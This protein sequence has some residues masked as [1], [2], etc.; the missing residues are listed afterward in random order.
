M[1]KKTLWCALTLVLLSAAAMSGA[2]KRPM[3]DAQF[4]ISASQ[5]FM[6]M[7]SAS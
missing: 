2:L 4:S 6:K 3:L 1:C 7:L 5:F